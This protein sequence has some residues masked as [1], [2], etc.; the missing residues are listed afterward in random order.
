[1]TTAV[2][3][4]TARLAWMMVQADGGYSQP[5]RL[6]VRRTRGVWES[7][8]QFEGDC[9]SCVLEAAYQAGLPT[10]SASYTGDMRGELAAAGVDLADVTSRLEYDGVAKFEIA[11]ADLI[12]AVTEQLHDH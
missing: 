6:D 8:F 7:G 12:R 1:M 10:G 11:W 2:D 3:V 4:F 9:S 5:H